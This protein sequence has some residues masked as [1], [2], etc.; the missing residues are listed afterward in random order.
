MISVSDDTACVSD[1]TVAL[2]GDPYGGTFSGQGVSYNVFSPY[3]PGT[4]TVYYTYTDLNGCFNVD[5]TNIFVEICS[6]VD[7]VGTSESKAY[8]FLQS[9][10]IF[11]HIGEDLSGSEFTLFNPSGEKILNL[12]LQKTETVLN[13]NVL[14]AGIYF[15]QVKSDSNFS[16][17]KLMISK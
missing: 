16:S 8:C 6:G 12:K 14:S 1:A 15:Y 10:E 4:F 2:Y 5:S 7:P 17:G 13:V 11:I 9:N 3:T